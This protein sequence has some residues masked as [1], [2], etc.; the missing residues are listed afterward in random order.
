MATTTPT[1][2]SVHSHHINVS[3]GENAFSTLC[4]KQL[5]FFKINVGDSAIHLLVDDST[6]VDNSKTPAEW[7]VI[8]KAV[9]I[10]GGK[11]TGKG[12]ILECVKRIEASYT[13]APSKTPGTLKYDAIMITHWDVNH[14]GGIRQLIRD[15]IEETL[16][17]RSDLKALVTTSDVGT[18]TDNIS[19]LYPA[20]AGLQ[21]PIFKYGSSEGANIFQKTPKQG[22]A[23]P[24]LPTVASNTLQTT[25]YVPYDTAAAAKKGG[26]GS[27]ESDTK[28]KDEIVQGSRNTFI[29]NRGDYYINGGANTLGA[30]AFHEY[31]IG[32]AA[33]RKKGFKFFDLCKVVAWYGDYLG[34]EVFSGESLPSGTSYRDITNPGKLIKAHGSSMGPRMYIVAGDQVIIGN[35]PLASANT[36]AAPVT[37]VPSAKA[38]FTPIGIRGR[39]NIVDETK[40]GLGDRVSGIRSKSEDINSASIACLI[41]SSTT[42]NPTAITA[43]Q[44]GNSWRLWHYMVILQ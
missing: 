18:K 20:V 15:T 14:W 30:L 3:A 12:P 8:Y 13:F 2:L 4:M 5:M 28:A 17:K 33:T 32:S 25:L 37:S 7:P 21:I 27:K 24:I 43:A 11:T 6:A 41:L 44:E 38:K 34:V 35:T 29:C 36:V 42:S 10:D 23:A 39:V 22:A 1:Q 40:P 31:K 19:T 26:L 16:E 9:L